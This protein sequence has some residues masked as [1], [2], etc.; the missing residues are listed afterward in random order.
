MIIITDMKIYRCVFLCKMIVTVR[1]EG[2]AVATLI[3]V[4]H[5]ATKFCYLINFFRCQSFLTIDIYLI[6]LF[7]AKRRD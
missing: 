1:D 6:N 3:P 7:L 5:I 4:S 2:I